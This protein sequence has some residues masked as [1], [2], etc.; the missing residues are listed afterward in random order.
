MY[1]ILIPSYNNLKY[2]EFCITSILK[3]SKYNHQIIVHVNVGNDGTLDYLKKIKLNTLLQI[4]MLEF[5]R[6]LIKLQN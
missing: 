2:L 5:V 3:N 1:S 4:I 6:E